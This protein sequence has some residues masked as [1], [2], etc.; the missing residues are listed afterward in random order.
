LN[1]SANGAGKVK[2]TFPME[3]VGQTITGVVNITGSLTVDD[4]TFN[5]GIISTG[6]GVNLTLQPGGAGM[7]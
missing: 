3:T 7:F 4:I 2:T 6:D 1:L 5:A